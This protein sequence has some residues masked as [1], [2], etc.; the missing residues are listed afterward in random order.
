VLSAEPYS[1]SPIG[2]LT[3]LRER[4]VTRFDGFR[5]ERRR[6]LETTAPFSDSD[7]ELELGTWGLGGLLGRSDDFAGERGISTL[8]MLISATSGVG[9]ELD[10]GCVLMSAHQTHNGNGSAYL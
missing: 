10:L 5:E 6:Y 7:S 9:I 3:A 8:S 2:V 4:L 1:S